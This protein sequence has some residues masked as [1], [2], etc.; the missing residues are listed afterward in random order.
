MK[1]NFKRILD[2]AKRTGDTMIVTDPDGENAFVVMDIDQYEMLTDIEGGV[3]L[4]SEDWSEEDE[5]IDDFDLY[6][7]P[8]EN[9]VKEI[10]PVKDP[11]IWDTMKKAGDN[12]ETWDVS[13]MSENEILELEKQ[14]RDYT[15][16]GVEE[17]ISKIE[18]VPE[19]NFTEKELKIDED[20]GEEQ[21]YL[22]PV[23]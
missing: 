10:E 13:K 21:F 16:Q 1:D 19:E 5:V 14:Y 8:Q 17:E 2:L 22:E 6:E 12:S 9:P 3:D 23:E 4:Y 15:K 7:A 11:E 20:F 18:A